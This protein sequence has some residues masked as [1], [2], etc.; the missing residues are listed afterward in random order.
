MGAEV[1]EAHDAR[2]A[3]ALREYYEFARDRDL[4][5]TYVIINPLADRTRSAHEQTDDSLVA[6]IC[7]QDSQGITV[8]GAKMLG[9]SAVMANEVLVTSIQPLKSGDEPYAFSFAVPMNAPAT[10][11]SKP[12]PSP[13]APAARPPAMRER[14]E[15]EPRIFSMNPGRE[16][17]ARVAARAKSWG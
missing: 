3:A 6:R 4:F 5:L 16:I 11:P 9:T 2:R 17:S 12:T 7:D 10:P 13:P 8:K 14:P 15:P 1:F